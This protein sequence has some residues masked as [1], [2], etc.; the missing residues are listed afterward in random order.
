MS[1][2]KPGDSHT[3]TL[4]VLLILGLRSVVESQVSQTRVH[5]LGVSCVGDTLPQTPVDS[6]SVWGTRFPRHLW[7]YTLAANPL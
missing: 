6:Q 5:Q 4:W 3:L 7:A 2:V 1:G